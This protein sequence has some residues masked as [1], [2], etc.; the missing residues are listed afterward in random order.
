MKKQKNLLLR[1]V[2]RAVLALAV[3]LIPLVMPIIEAHS[4]GSGQIPVPMPRPKANVGGGAPIDAV[5]QQDA[6]PAMIEPVSAETTGAVPPI[7][8]VSGSLRQGLDA[9]ADKDVQRALAIREGMRTGSFERRVL[10]WSIA[11]SGQE[12]ISSSE[13]ARVTATLGGDAVVFAAA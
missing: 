2:Q 13:I 10:D 7:P 5:P 9:L 1:T 6:E 11:I 8:P 3:G 4:Q 12:G